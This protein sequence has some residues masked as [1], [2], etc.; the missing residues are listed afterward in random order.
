MTQ[1]AQYCAGKTGRSFDSYDALHRFSTDELRTFWRLFLDWSDLAY[2][3]DPTTVCTS[4]EVERAVFFP[5]LRLNY[6]D[7]LL[8]RTAFDEQQ[9]AIL[10]QRADGSAQRLTRKQLREQVEACASGFKSLGI[11]V[12]SR[13]AM[14]ASNDLQAVVATLAAAAVGATVGT[15]A[16]ETGVDAS[17][18]RFAPIE[19]ELL[20]CHWCTPN[21]DW[22][23]RL[24]QRI[25][26]IIGS[27]PSL[28]NVVLLDR[29]AQQPTGL[30]LPCHL[31]DEFMAAH[32]GAPA[33]WPQLPFNHPL[34][35][36][37]S[38]GTTGAPKAI[39]HGAG[40]T[41]LEHLKEHRLH[42]DLRAGER[43][44]YQTSTAW[45]MWNWVLT[46]LASGVELVLYDGP[47][48]NPDTLW[49][50]VAEK[51]VTVFGTS[52]AYLQLGARAE[53]RPR[54]LGLSSLR[55]ILSTGSI[56]YPEQQQWVT[57][58]VKDLPVLSISGGTDI[59]GCFV[60]CNPNLPA[61]PGEPQC[62]GLAF[63]LDAQPLEGASNSRIGELVCR[64][65]F[66]SRPI[67]FLQDPA[68]T[69]FHEAYFSQNPPFWT[70]GDLVEFK[71]NGSVVMHGRS[72][73]TINIRGIRIGPAEIYRVLEGFSEIEGAM[74]IEQRH[75]SDLGHAR[76]VLL[77]VLA[78][79]M[80]L[81]EALQRRIRKTI[82]GQVSAAHVPAI[83]IQVPA[84]PVTNTGKQSERSARDAV[85]GDH[86]A[87]R[88]ALRNPECLDAIAKHP[89]LRR[90][91]TSSAA[92]YR[93]LLQPD[94]RYSEAVLTQL[95]EDVLGIAPIGRDEDF[96]DIG[97]SSISALQLLRRLEAE[98]GM[99][100]PVTFMYNARTI[101]RMAAQLQKREFGD[102][103]DLVVINPRGSGRPLFIVHGI[104]GNV[105]ALA[106]LGRSISHDGPVYAI[107][108][109]GLSGQEPPLDSVPAMAEAYLESIRT[110]QPSGPYL[111][112]GHSF[113]GL[114]A[115]EMA[116]QLRILDERAALTILLDTTVD[117]RYWP[118]ADWINI[119]INFATTRI[120][121]I[122]GAPP[123]EK[124]RH[125]KR[126]L[127]G[128]GRRLQHRGGKL[129]V[130][131]LDEATEPLP[132]NLQRVRAAAVRAMAGYY[133]P[134]Y[135]GEVVL[136]RCAVK[137]PLH[138]RAR[139]SRRTPH[140]SRG[141]PRD[142]AGGLHHANAQIRR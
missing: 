23:D 26:D 51:N 16:P 109:R 130:A 42:C 3:G 108:A 105:M 14:L 56:L 129:P 127:R 132:E 90:S 79:G 33:N 119:M 24:Q 140:I 107:K 18:A 40:G 10:S 2:S 9:P 8:S 75:D 137:N 29:V 89:D 1:F 15:S 13:V 11:G 99:P 97:V 5:E 28:R 53:L 12:G 66:P 124:L 49:K 77:L 117:E 54:T 114:V 71:A 32:R 134:Y 64:K 78:P 95:W 118:K 25:R 96:I 31:L 138:F 39:V 22:D 74:A 55:A 135:D 83:I 21:G 20:V 60:M 93:P 48:A 73:G 142:D 67:G 139:G 19:P 126:R 123:K 45:M 86:I 65:P 136:L 112:A 36:L 6:A 41:L 106:K 37:F 70:H 131:T 68:G 141:T 61:Y 81:Q 43:L 44:F 115:F 88:G 82:G 87:N 94:G 133:P 92:S 84:L 76:L 103:S 17:V 34:F 59:I 116:R 62:K 46:A 102:G 91:A 35:I 69:R 38:S 113:G 30:P 120:R 125:L 98:V 111:L 101:A 58:S 85:N 110:I 27:L 122:A 72:D 121:E 128:L 7:I 100:L 47:V 52:P 57:D 104:G 4:E 50:I 80:Q 63:D